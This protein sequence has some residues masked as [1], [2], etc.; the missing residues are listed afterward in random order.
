MFQIVRG[1][2]FQQHSYNCCTHMYACVYVVN[3]SA[4]KNNTFLFK[5]IWLK[6]KPNFDDKMIEM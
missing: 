5:F 6:L 1:K 2:Q 4:S 3:I